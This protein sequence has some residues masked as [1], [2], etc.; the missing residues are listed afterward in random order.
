MPSR[1]DVAYF[2]AGPAPL[3]TVVLEKGAEAFVNF[4][5]T[6]LSLAEISHR[7]QTANRILADTKAALASLL[8]IPD[9]HEILFMHGGG[10][11]EFSAVV[12]NMVAVWVEKRRRKAE[13]EFGGDEQKIHDT[14]KSELRDKLRLDY[15]VTG[16]WSLKASQEAANLL[17][18]L[19]KGFVNVAVDSRQSNGGKFGTIP[20]EDTWN[21][22]PSKSQGGQSSSFV[23]YC[24]NETVDGVEFPGLP[25]CLDQSSSDPDN[26]LL[27]VADMSSNFLSRRVDVSKYAVIFVSINV[28]K[29]FRNILTR[30]GRC[31]KKHWHHRCHS[32][33]CAQGSFVFISFLV[34]PACCRCLVTTNHSQLVCHCE[35]QFP[36]QYHANLQHLDR[37]RSD[38][39]IDRNPRREGAE[40]PGGSGE[41]ESQS[42]LRCPRHLS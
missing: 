28:P 13:T 15:L 32:R 26:E 1:E 29:N 20:S 37:R 33:N 42:H 39:R 2:G 16:S 17:E 25:K 22:T 10:S 36:L 5:N 23:Y 8:Q 30:I 12:L 14:V 40:R 41:P 4:E 24:D 27:V 31:A 38:A 19:G 9:S 21:L 34:V 18:P 3:P 7:S 11:A 6:G 35:E